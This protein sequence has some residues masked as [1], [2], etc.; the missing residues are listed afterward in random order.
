MNSPCDK[1]RK[2]QGA[3]VVKEEG[4][5]ATAVHAAGEAGEDVVSDAGEEHE[6]EGI[7]EE[8]P[9]ET[10]KD[11]PQETS[12]EPT[13]EPL[14]EMTPEKSPKSDDEEEKQD[15]TP[16]DSPKNIFGASMN[17]NE[18]EFGM[19]IDPEIREQQDYIKA[20]KPET[21]LE[22]ALSDDL[23]RKGMHIKRLT[24]EVVK[25][26]NFISKRKQTY[27]RK[28]K[29]TGAPVRALSAY[30]IFVQERF[31][32]LSKENEVALKSA[33]SEAQLKR[34][35][36][37]SL[38]ASTGNQWKEL[39]AEEKAYYE[40][41]AKADR[42]RY[43]EEMSSYNPPEKPG[44]RKRNKT[45]YNVFFS[46]HV[47]RLKQTEAGVPSER[48]S[49]ARLVGEAW[50]Q[51]SPEEKQ[52][53]ER[54]ADRNNQEN[55]VEKSREVEHDDSEGI[56]AKLPKTHKDQHPSSSTLSGNLSHAGASMGSYPPQDYSMHQGGAPGQGGIHPEHSQYGGRDMYGQYG[57][58]G[59]AHAPSHQTY[60]YP[61]HSSQA[62]AYGYAPPP[63]YGYPQ[64]GYSHYGDGNP[65][66]V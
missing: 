58:Y 3:V 1:G 33:D 7:S 10:A 54:E 5:E 43:E 23:K 57:M 64:H 53:Y 19:P 20:H 32:R 44:S 51:L 27:K 26:K 15:A 9:P 30:N 66:G 59:G 61:Q 35:P 36:P 34:V 62:D 16:E 56:S 17:P 37:A 25:L 48:G 29:E 12:D 24:A 11:A 55:P 41:K 2:D 8:T 40:V 49:V 65:T 46:Q 28:R 52:Y 6:T 45:G 13:Q 47:L 18:D 63:H 4:P 42:R 22:M 14:E 60:G 50:K 31:K 21:E 38:V 39:G